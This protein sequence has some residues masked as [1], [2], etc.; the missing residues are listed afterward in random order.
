VAFAI[1]MA[2][3]VSASAQDRH[4]KASQASPGGEALNSQLVTTGL[5][6]I[7]GGGANSLL[8]LSTTGLILVDGKLPGYHRPLMSQVRRINKM[9]DLP[10][11]FLIVTGHTESHT[12]N[13]ALFLAKGVQI[14]A[15]ENAARRL[16]GPSSGGGTAT[17]GTIVT[18]DREYNLLQGGI[19]V[20]L[21]HFGRARTDGDTVVYFPNQKVVAVG[22]LFTRGMPEPDFSAGGSLV[23]WSQVLSRILELD[24]DVVV[25]STGS[26]ATR[27]DLEAFKKRIDALASYASALVKKGVTKDRLMAELN[28]GNPGWDVS[29]TGEA[30]DRFYAEL[31]E[32]K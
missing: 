4:E 30:L 3:V 28:A 18:Y 23:N 19:E 15:Q 25:P 26:K 1:A 8:R 24:F 12:G 21:R 2:T 31:S 27:E 29:L 5:Y 13:N 20:Q 6:L 10:V 7:S 11:K 9:T 17:T 32:A 22:D 16:Q 14:I